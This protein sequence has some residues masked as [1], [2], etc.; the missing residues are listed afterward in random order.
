MTK[1]KDVT[2]ENQTKEV[3]AKTYESALVM[4][5]ELTKDLMILLKELPIKYSNDVIPLI[6]RLNKSPRAN[7]TLN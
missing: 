4:D 2:N 3:E 6:D 1:I 5:K 7:V